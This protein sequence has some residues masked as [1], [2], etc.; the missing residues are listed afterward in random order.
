MSDT[1][2][3][4]PNIYFYNTKLSFHHRNCN[5]GLPE[6]PAT[7]NSTAAVYIISCQTTGQH[8]ITSGKPHHFFHMYHLFMV[9]A[10]RRTIPFETMKF[11]ITLDTSLFS[12]AVYLT[13][14]S[15]AHT[16]N[17]KLKGDQQIMNW[18]GC[19]R[20]RLWPGIGLVRLVALRWDCQFPERDIIISQAI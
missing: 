19:A 7:S 16:M 18:T 17:I 2:Q 1:A 4:T 6:K 15:V 5:A 12:F 3:N 13:M 14:L 9:T 8:I 10:D 11:T 20:K